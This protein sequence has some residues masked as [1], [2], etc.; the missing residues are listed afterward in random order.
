M[1]RHKIKDTAESQQMM[2]A[3]GDNL[4]WRLREKHMTQSSLAKLLG[5]SSPT[6][7]A[8]CAGRIVPS[9]YTLLRICT[10]LQISPNKLLGWSEEESVPEEPP[11]PY[12]AVRLRKLS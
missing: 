9:V 2:N 12:A 1:S 4:H 8:Y 5:L 10:L 3:F 7:Q 6:V 11:I